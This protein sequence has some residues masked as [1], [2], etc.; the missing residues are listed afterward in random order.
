MLRNRRAWICLLSFGTLTSCNR[1]TEPNGI[2]PPI[3]HALSVV[4]G[5]GAGEIDVCGTLQL[6][7]SVHDA[8]GALVAPDSTKWWSSDTT[9]IGISLSGMS[10]ARKAAIVDTL[11]ATSWK[12]GD[13]GTGQLVMNVNDSRLAIGPCPTGGASPCVLPCPL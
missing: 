6:T 7:V 2:V 13:T 5:P 3:S 8:T 11:R 4:V 12:S 10:H 1:S 9:V